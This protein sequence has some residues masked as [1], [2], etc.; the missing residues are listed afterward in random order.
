[1]DSHRLHPRVRKP[2]A[3]GRPALRP[4]RAQADVPDRRDRPAARL[5]DGRRRRQLQRAAP[6]PYRPGHLRG[7]ARAGGPV[8]A[9][10]D[11]LGPGGGTWPRFRCFRRGFRRR[12]RTG[13]AAGRRANRG[14]VMALE[15][16]R[17]PDFRRG[18]AAGRAGLPARDDSPQ[19][20]PLDLSG[21][22]AATL[23]LLGIVSGLGNA[24][25][26]G[27]SGRHPRPAP[28]RAG[29]DDHFRAHRTSHRAAD[30]AA[31]HCSRSNP[32][33]RI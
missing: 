26:N 20:M 2:L 32:R 9:V 5:S 4:L 19:R 28:R 21:A 24:A 11:F 27:W 3:S 12:R 33:R 23:G 30:V 25:A 22:I 7:A 15:P 18:R 1:M 31:A 13:P 10:R 6:G 17:Q 29:A 16:L 14:A 8:P